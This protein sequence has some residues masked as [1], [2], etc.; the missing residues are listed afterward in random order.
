VLAT[1]DSAD[2]RALGTF[3]SKHTGW[4]L[5]I[6][7]LGRES[8]GRGASVPLAM[9]FIIGGLAIAGTGFQRYR[10]G[11]ALYRHPG[12]VA[13]FSLRN[14]KPGTIVVATGTI[15]RAESRDERVVIYDEYVYRVRPKEGEYWELVSSNRPGFT[16][17]QGDDH[18]TILGGQYTLIHP[19]HQWTDGG[20]RFEGF[21]G[22]DLV[23]VLGTAAAD[24]DQRALQARQVF[25]G[26]VR[27]FGQSV[28]QQGVLDMLAGLGSILVGGV[29]LAGNLRL[30]RQLWRRL[31]GRPSSGRIQRP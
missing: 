22:G 13:G 21:W 1:G 14:A 16:V 12:A 5:R 3:L 27:Q 25:G 23:T 24:R 30:R 10:E 11:L 19:Y 29:L 28:R 4:P 9:L 17:S 2:I 26:T 8:T 6:S 15:E 20:G 18:T 7:R 31:D